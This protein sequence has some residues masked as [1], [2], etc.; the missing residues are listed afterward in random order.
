MKPKKVEHRGETYNL[1][2]QEKLDMFNEMLELEKELHKPARECL[3]EVIKVAE[4]QSVLLHGKKKH[5]IHIDLD[6]DGNPMKL[7][8]NKDKRMNN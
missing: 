5:I 6:K 1:D 2:T 8:D 7:Y 3:S 4:I